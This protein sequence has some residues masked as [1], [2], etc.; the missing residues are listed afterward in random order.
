MTINWKDINN[1]LPKAGLEFVAKNPT[2]PV[3][4]KKSAKQCR[5]MKF[6][7]SFEPDQI[8]SLMNK[9]NLIL[10]SSL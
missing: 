9:D 8:Y 10:W 2:I 1:E 5:V 6:N 3:D 4:P 7:V